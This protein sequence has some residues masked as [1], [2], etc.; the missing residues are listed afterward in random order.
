MGF[1]VYNSQGEEL[2]N[3]TGTAGGDLTGTY[4]NPDIAAGKVGASELAIIPACRLTRTS[5]SQAISRNTFTAIT[6]D[7]EA[8][9]TDSMHSTSSNTSRITIN[10]AGL[11]LFSGFVEGPAAGGAVT[12]M[13][14]QI[15]KNG[16]RVFGYNDYGENSGAYSGITTLAYEASVGDYFELFGY[17][18]AASGTTTTFSGAGFSATRL[19]AIA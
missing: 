17:W 8:F 1:Q 16:S 12:Y 11:Y 2:Q 3:L 15:Y 19:G 6:F 7:S 5:T 9:D 10:T 4:P 13:L 18:F 14:A